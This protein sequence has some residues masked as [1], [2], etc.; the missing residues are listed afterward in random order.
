[1]WDVSGTSGLEITSP[2]FWNPL[3]DSRRRLPRAGR[4]SDARPRPGHWACVRHFRPREGH[5]AVQTSCH[6][7]RRSPSQMPPA[8]VTVCAAA[9]PAQL[10]VSVSVSL[11]PVSGLSF[12][13]LSPSLLASVVAPPSHSYSRLSF[14]DVAISLSSPCSLPTSA[15]PCAPALTVALLLL[16]RYSFLPPCRPP[17]LFLS[18]CPSGCPDPVMEWTQ[19]PRKKTK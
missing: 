17:S 3:W 10:P 9:A 2:E 16:L 1:V 14:C 11:S 19:A 4:E 8:C 18:L 7:A 6:L 5:G 15:P 13:V 12:L